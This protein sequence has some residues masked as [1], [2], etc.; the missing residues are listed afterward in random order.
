MEHGKRYGVDAK[1]IGAGIY[2]SLPE[3]DRGPIAFGMAP[4]WLMEDAEKK[5]RHRLAENVVRENYGD[6]M[7]KDAEIVQMYADAIYPHV[8]Q[9]IMKGFYLGLLEAAKENHAL[10]V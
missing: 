7:V 4:Q 9:E 2:N 3:K 10:V 1:A 6:E 8:M 5:I